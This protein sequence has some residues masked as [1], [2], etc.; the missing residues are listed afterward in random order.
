ML[1]TANTQ[2]LKKE[3]QMMEEIAKLAEL[4]LKNQGKKGTM[5]NWR[6]GKALLRRE[7]G[8]DEADGERRTFKCR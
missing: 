8:A 5:V 6:G 2:G 3:N 4:I 7:L 1:R